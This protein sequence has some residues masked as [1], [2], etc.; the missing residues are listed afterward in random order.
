MPA[1]SKAARLAAP[2]DETAEELFTDR[3]APGGTLAG[4]ALAGDAA[5]GDAGFVDVEFVVAD[6]TVADRI[7]AGFAAIAG[8]DTRCQCAPSVV[9]RITPARPTT[10]AASSDV[11]S[12][13][14]RSLRT[15]L[16]CFP[17]V[18][19]RSAERSMLPA[20]PTR[21]IAARLGEAKMCTCAAVNENI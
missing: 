11:A 17:Q 9:R 7:V 12:P 6:C 15:P 20:A 1:Q 18:W 16:A 14:T 19:P 10:Q 4:G 8:K 2:E 21:H 3:A 5:R 13:A